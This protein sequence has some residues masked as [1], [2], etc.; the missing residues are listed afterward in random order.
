MTAIT[1]FDVQD[2]LLEPHE[3]GAYAAK[4]LN[5]TPERGRLVPGRLRA[6]VSSA[7]GVS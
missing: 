5:N 4:T 3:A 7:R 1:T 2:G 6:R